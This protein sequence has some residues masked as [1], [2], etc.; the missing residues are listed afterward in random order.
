MRYTET[1][2][3]ALFAVAM[4]GV[5]EILIP[6]T[7]V[8][9]VVAVLVVSACAVPVIVTVGAAV[10]VPFDVV[11]GMVAGAV[12]RPLSLSMLPQVPA[13]TPVAQVAAHVTTVSL[14]PVTSE[15]I[16]SV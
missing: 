9:V 4:A 2:G 14:L 1:A 11:V 10:V 12:Y 16:W 15:F 5:I 13:V 8:I 6:V 7:I 3:L